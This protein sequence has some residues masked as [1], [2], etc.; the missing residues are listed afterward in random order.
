M[1][2]LLPS[3]RLL[4]LA[5]LWAPS[6]CQDVVTTA[7][8]STTMADNV[9]AVVIHEGITN[10]CLVCG[11]RMV[12][13]NPN[14]V[15]STSLGMFTCGGL[16]GIGRMG[17]IGEGQCLAAKMAALEK[18]DCI[19]N[20][21]TDETPSE[22]P[23]VCPVCSDDKIVTV[24]D[25]VVS[26]ISQPNRTCAEYMQAS[27]DG[28]IQEAQCGLLQQFTTEACG[29]EDEDTSPSPPVED[30]PTAAPQI[31]VC[32]VCGAGLMVTDPD[33]I[34]SIANQPDRTCADM[35]TAATDGEITHQ[36]CALLQPFVQQSCRCETA[37]AIEP[38]PTPAPSSYDCAICGEGMMV[39]IA[40]AIVQIPTQPNRTCTELLDANGKGNIHAAQCSLLRQF[41]LGPCGCM[42][43]DET[44][45]PSSMPS[46]VPSLVPTG[47]TQPTIS[48]SP[49][50]YETP[51]PGCFDDLTDIYELERDLD[52]TSLHRKYI[53]CPGTTFN[54][55]VLNDDLK[56]IDGQTFLM[57]RP[58]VIYQCG[59][60]GSRLN[61][62][63][64]K[65]GDFALASYYGVFEGIYETVE[66]VQIKG[67]SFH[68]QNMFA[69]VMEAAG[70]IAFI[71]CAFRVSG[72][73]LAHCIP[74]TDHV[75]VD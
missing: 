51:K 21:A 49:T 13:S 43:A 11:E 9:T 64:L 7:E 58:N 15:I 36:Q 62:C 75:I 44:L 26:I 73:K 31:Y 35:E 37:V 33:A 14:K 48:P 18:C 50:Y 2:P 20:G 12:V 72:T 17:N 59:E 27:V 5:L 65:G 52:D 74:R 10:V 45:K 61:D 3:I 46:D 1:R 63:I 6:S 53:L 38:E 4:L 32:P 60:D 56:I 29:C 54:M 34:V 42:P 23:Y 69:A 68:S 66:N 70:D 8:N 40:D 47:P 39:T 57:L 24:P 41:V 55:G 30:P 25:G 67:L 22:E 71:D 19:A 28:A 16:V